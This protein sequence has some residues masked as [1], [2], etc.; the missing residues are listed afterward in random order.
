MLKITRRF[1]ER[2]IVSEF[3]QADI[4]SRRTNI[5]GTVILKLK[6]DLVCRNR[7]FSQEKNR[8]NEENHNNIFSFKNS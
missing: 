6:F 8:N 4:K 1:R 3:C 7:Y 5:Y 2:G